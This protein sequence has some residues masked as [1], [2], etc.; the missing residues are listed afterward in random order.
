MINKQNHNTID[1]FTGIKLKT[2]DGNLINWIRKNGTT[3]SNNVFAAG[4]ALGEILL[5]VNSKNQKLT[6]S[7]LLSG[8]NYNDF[9][10][11]SC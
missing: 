9:R 1:F 11:Y 2:A 5:G 8:G 4:L 6:S 10:Q 3:A 7:L